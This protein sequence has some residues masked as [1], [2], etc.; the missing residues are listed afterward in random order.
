[1]KAIKKGLR[2]KKDNMRLKGLAR[3]VFYRAK[4]YQGENCLRYFL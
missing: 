3:F 1:V 2:D 4:F